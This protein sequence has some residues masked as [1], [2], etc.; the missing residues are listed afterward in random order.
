MYGLDKMYREM[1]DAQERGQ[2][3][4]AKKIAKRIEFFYFTKKLYKFPIVFGF[5]NMEKLKETMAPY[6]SVV[7]RKDCEDLS[8]LIETTRYYEE[9]IDEYEKALAKVKNQSHIL[10]VQQ[11]LHTTLRMGLCKEEIEGQTLIWCVFIKEIEDLKVYLQNDFKV[12]TLYG[13]TPNK[14]KRIK[15]FQE[16][17]T[18]VLIIQPQA[19][20]EGI[21]LSGGQKIIWYSHPLRAV[22]VKQAN[23]RASKILGDKIHIQRL[24]SVGTLDDYL[25]GLLERK[26][27]LA[28]DIARVGL[29]EVI[30]QISKKVKIQ[31]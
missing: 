31:A 22:L 26:S 9:D 13:K 23:E 2:S 14:Q 15:D 5:Q 8:P 28:E 6:A 16:K 18:Q 25:L 20:G 29:Q 17:R 10:S 24:A 7:L 27:S 4:Q 12:E 1:L 30:S 21:D 11:I 19:G 3:N